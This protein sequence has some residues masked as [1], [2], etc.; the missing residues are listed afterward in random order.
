M[1]MP[2][3]ATKISIARFQEGILRINKGSRSI[4]GSVTFQ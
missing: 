4:K 1:I 3:I 2:V